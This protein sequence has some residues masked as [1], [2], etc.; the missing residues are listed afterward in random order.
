MITMR[1]IKFALQV[2][3]LSVSFPVLFIT[4]INSGNAGSGKETFQQVDSLTVKNHFPAAEKSM[5]LK[6]STSHNNA[7]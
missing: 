3:I 6:P 2:F 1:K 4:G 5:A 7:L